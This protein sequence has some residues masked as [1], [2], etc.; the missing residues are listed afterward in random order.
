MFEKY[1]PFVVSTKY[2][3]EINIPPS[4]INFNVVNPGNSI[5]FS[6]RRVVHQT[7]MRPWIFLLS[8]AF[9]VT[10]SRTMDISS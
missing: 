4:A 3:G 8:L 5:S 2:A 7:N 9:L 10:T 6:I 1:I